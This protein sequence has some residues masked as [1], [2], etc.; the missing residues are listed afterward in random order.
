MRVA[1]CYPDLYEIGMSNMGLAIL[2]DLV[3]RR[4]DMLAERAYTPWPDMA[5]AMRR[6]EIPL[7]S[8]ET[9]HPLAEFDVVGFTLQYELNYTN[10]L[11]MLD[12]AGIPLHSGERDERWPLVIAGGSSNYNPEPL[13]DFF[14]L[15][16][17]GE[18]EEV[19]FELLDL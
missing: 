15:F 14:D 3:N 13:A 12:L 10:V 2:Y 4:P 6:A 9:R 1:L 17:I 8:L 7:Y 5:A 11:E 16:A 19:L 18:G